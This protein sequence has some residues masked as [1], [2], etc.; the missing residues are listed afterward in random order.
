MARKAINVK[1]LYCLL[2][3]DLIELDREKQKTGHNR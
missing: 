1:G 2:C 3:S